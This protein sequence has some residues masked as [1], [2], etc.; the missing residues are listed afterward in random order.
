MVTS[1]DGINDEMFITEEDL[2]RHEQVEIKPGD[3]MINVI[4][5][6]VLG[7]IVVVDILIKDLIITIEHVSYNKISDTYENIDNINEII[8]LANIEEVINS[9]YN[10]HTK[11]IHSGKFDRFVKK[12]NIS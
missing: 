2:M 6:S 4:K 7:Y 3:T 10:G 1:G 11:I 8:Y 9:L 12:N 5:Y